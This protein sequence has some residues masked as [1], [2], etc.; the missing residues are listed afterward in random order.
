MTTEKRNA[1]CIPDYPALEGEVGQAAV[2]GQLRYYP[3]VVRSMDDSAPINQ[4]FST[5][6]FMLF[7]EERRLPSGQRVFGYVKAR[8]SFSDKDQAT[9]EMSKVI[10]ECDSR[11]TVNIV[12]TGSWIPITEDQTGARE[13][14]EVR[15]TDDED[16]IKREA[17]KENE[18]KTQK[19]IR[20][21]KAREDEL[22]TDGD[23]Y[24]N[25]E[26]LRYFT[27]K[28]VTE[29]TLMDRRDHIMEQLKSVNE[30]L[31]KTQLELYNL[32]SF[33]PEYE[34][35]WIDCY[36]TE[37][38]KGGLP[39]F[40]PSQKQTDEHNAAMAKLKEDGTVPTRLKT[41]VTSAKDDFA[42]KEPPKIKLQTRKVTPQ[43]V[44]LVTDQAPCTPARAEELLIKHDFNFAKAIMEAKEEGQ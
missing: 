38:R 20:E 28:K 32:S 17:L 39:D 40:V 43:M 37:R 19:Q 30:N 5:L 8:G 44:K 18:A 34:E 29:N 10:K 25:P 42:V 16:A 23:I 26:S 9:K 4:S 24:D 14:I 1:W 41:Q 2:N 15:T 33:N 13:T 35:D 22:R 21:L 6:S 12:S 7:K 31:A 27:M 11:F 3:K 36:N